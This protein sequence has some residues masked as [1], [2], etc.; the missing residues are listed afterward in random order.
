MSLNLAFEL[1][2]L[3]SLSLCSVKSNFLFKL[4]FF[5]TFLLAAA[6][7]IQLCQKSFKICPSENSWPQK[8]AVLKMSGKPK[9]H[10]SSERTKIRFFSQGW[11]RV[12]IFGRIRFFESKN[13]LKITEMP[14]ARPTH[15]LDR[16]RRSFRRI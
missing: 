12:K 3:F 2:R 4:Q 10:P 16:G 9:I 1:S 13:R 15:A 6:V 11:K 8:F 7:S 14:P 5:S